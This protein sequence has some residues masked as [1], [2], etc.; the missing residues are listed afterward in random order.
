MRE[1]EGGE[2]GFVDG[3]EGED[4]EGEVVVPGVILVLG[5]GM[6]VQGLAALEAETGEEGEDDGAYGG[7]FGD[8]EG[9]RLNGV[10]GDAT[11]KRSVV[12]GGYGRVGLR[13]G[14]GE[15]E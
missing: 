15:A 10:E 14:D 3:E 8:G 5:L 11:W 9:E 12:G 1:G 2:G 6:K 13:S 4:E 7:G